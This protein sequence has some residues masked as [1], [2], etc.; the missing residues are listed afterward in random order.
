M[1]IASTDLVLLGSLNRPED[2]TATSGGGKDV[3]N[4]PD[5]T[6]MAANDTIEM[7]SDNA[8][9]TTQSVTVTG[10]DAAGAILADTK[11]LNGTTPVAFTGT[12]ERVLK[13]LMD[14]DAV[15]TVT[16]RRVTGPVTIRTIPVGERGFSMLFQRAASESGAVSRFEKV[17]WINNHGTL[18]LTSAQVQ[19]TADPASKLFTGVVVAKDDSTSVANRK[20]APAGVTFV[21]DN[22]QQSVP[23]TTLE[24]GAAIGVWMRQ[25]LLASDAPVR[26]T[27]TLELAGNSA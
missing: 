15:G 27:Y 8:G 5:F 17:F 11:T 12:F 18:T 21:D 6:Q 23:G 25:D 10:R 4:R 7:V 14:S 9:D 3:D 19:M 16:I 26:N 13:V 22:V 24:A 2:D 1:A 20:A